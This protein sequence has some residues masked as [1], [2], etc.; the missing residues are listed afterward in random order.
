[1]RTPFA[2]RDW[3]MAT[4]GCWLMAV[5]M[6]LSLTERVRGRKPEAIPEEALDELMVPC[7]TVVVSRAA[8]AAWAGEERYPCPSCKGSRPGC[9]T[10]AGTG[11]W[12]RTRLHDICPQCDGVGTVCARDVGELCDDGWDVRVAPGRIAGLVVDRR[13]IATLLRLLPEQRYFA[14]GALALTSVEGVLCIED[15]DR[16]WRVV[17]RRAEPVLRRAEPT[18]AEGEVVEFQLREVPTP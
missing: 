10:C 9:M 8:L 3:I 6:K 13:R 15:P 14:V 2:H 11:L 18:E 17:L 1:M 4:D 7:D 5:P 12:A 16:S